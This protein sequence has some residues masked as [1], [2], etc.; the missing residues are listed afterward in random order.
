MTQTFSMISKFFKTFE[1]P[2]APRATALFVFFLMGILGFLSLAV[3][4]QDFDDMRQE[5]ENQRMEEQSSPYRL[6]GQVIGPTGPAEN[7]TVYLEVRDVRER[8]PFLYLNEQT[9]TQG[10]FSFDLSSVTA[11]EI[12]LEVYTVSYRYTMSRWFERIP[13]SELP[14]SATINV[15]PGV[16]VRGNIVDE[17]GEPI[18]G[19]TLGGTDIITEETDSEGNFEIFGLNPGGHNIT[20]QKE[21]YTEVT[22]FFQN[23]QPGV[24][25]DYQIQMQSSSKFNGVVKNWKNEPVANARVVFQM[26]TRYKEERTSS[27]GEFTFI[28][29]P[30]DVEAA[31]VIV[32]PLDDPPTMTSIDR[33]KIESGE[34]E[35]SLPQ[36]SGLYGRIMLP[37]GFPAAGAQVRVSM[38]DETKNFFWNDKAN[39]EGYFH[40]ENLIP[41]N[42]YNVSIDPSIIEREF[43]MADL[44]IMED[45]QGKKYGEVWQWPEGHSSDFEVE[46]ENDTIKL[47]RTDSGDGGI[48]GEINYEATWNEDQNNFEGKMS[49]DALG[50]TGKFYLRPRGYTSKDNIVGEWVIAENYDPLT[51][52]YE[53]RVMEVSLPKIPAEK[54]ILAEFETAITVEGRVI[55]EENEFSGGNAIIVLSEKGDEQTYYGEIDFD[56]FFEIPC[57]PRGLA[58]IYFVNNE[59]GAIIDPQPINTESGFIEFNSDEVTEEPETFILEL[60]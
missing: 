30:T 31:D 29:I 55:S 36:P 6:T 35:L 4:A 52:C 12:A 51:I 38:I 20:V 24:I 16:V 59:S 39:S 46:I 60:N 7:V 32:Y 42:D 28:G 44:D 23:D 47:I 26:P 58:F 1:C 56:G 14:L 2:R 21:G 40:L 9:D 3:N 41:G 10:Y 8:R 53:P 27:D 45:A 33:E 17:L 13:R 5:L 50:L 22:E 43:A 19:V 11:F 15:T 34:L 54:M 57:V 18:E 49:A 48:A 37:N 25:E